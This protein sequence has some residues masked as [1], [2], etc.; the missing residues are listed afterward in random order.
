MLELNV[1]PTM[2]SNWIT[3]K[4]MGYLNEEKKVFMKYL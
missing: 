2:A 1:N 3:G 4:L